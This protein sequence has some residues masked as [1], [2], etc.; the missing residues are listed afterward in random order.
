M[1]VIIG[2]FTDTTS[3]DPRHRPHRSIIVV[4]HAYFYPE[5]LRA[6]AL[7]TPM[8]RHPERHKGE[9]GPEEPIDEPHR[10][11]FEHLTGEAVGSGYSCVQL[12]LAGEP[13][14]YHSDHQRWAAVAFLTPDAPV[15]SGTSFF[16]SRLTGIERAPDEDVLADERERMRVLPGDIGEPAW[17]RDVAS[18]ERDTYAGKLLDRT[19]WEEVDRVGNRF[20]R[21]VVWD[22]RLIHAATDYFGSTVLDGR[23]FRMW[24]WD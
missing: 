12:C 13:L 10:Q 3:R 9:R 19:A 8:T 17:L 18:L 4:D 16:R 14:V 21:L 7:G 22:A 20:G 11:L 15:A 23:L 2:R 1:A 5:A 6:D 24:F